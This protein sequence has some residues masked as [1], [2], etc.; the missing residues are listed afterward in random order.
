MFGVAD[1]L[2]KTVPAAFDVQNFT[3]FETPGRTFFARAQ[4][5]F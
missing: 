4:L 2:N 1:A 3:G 5:H